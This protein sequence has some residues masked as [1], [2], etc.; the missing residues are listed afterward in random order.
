MGLSG[1]KVDT[2]LHNTHT[3]LVGYEALF[4]VGVTCLQQLLR[5]KDA[6]FIAQGRMHS[7]HATP[8]LKPWAV[9]GEWVEREV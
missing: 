3:H 4:A 9:G 2:M 7:Y 1:K 6:V 8:I 5:D